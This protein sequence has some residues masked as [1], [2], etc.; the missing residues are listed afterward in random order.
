M[1]SQSKAF[2]EWISKQP[3]W[4]DRDMVKMAI[5]VAIL[6]GG[7]GFLFGFAAGQPDLS[8]MTVNYVRG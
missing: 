6:A 3:I 7:I 1:Q 2:N 5:L 4:H 8:G